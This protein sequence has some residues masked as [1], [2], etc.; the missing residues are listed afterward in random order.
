MVMH[1]AYS[2]ARKAWP[3][4]RGWLTAF[5][6]ALFL[7]P[8]MGGTVHSALALLVIALTCLI[9]V[10]MLMMLCLGARQLLKAVFKLQEPF[11]FFAAAATLAAVALACIGLFVLPAFKQLFAS[12]GANLPA[13]TLFLLE[14]HYLLLLPAVLLPFVVFRLR[15]Q[16]RREDYFA[17]ILAG[18]FFV[19]LVCVL[20]YVQVFK[21]GEAVA[22]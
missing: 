8:F 2:A 9:P 20:L 13:P 1:E 21:V 10:G 7:L 15:K 14:Y 18:E 4:W 3:N 16:P 12:F 17:A 19:L 5:F 22:G 11:N 6:V